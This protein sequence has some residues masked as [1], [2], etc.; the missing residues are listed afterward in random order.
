MERLFEILKTPSEFENSPD[1]IWTNE[2]ISPFIFQSHFNDEVYGGS[3]NEG[4]IV[5]SIKFIN[6]IAEN[7][8]CL[9]ILDLGCGPG[10]YSFPLAKLGYHVTGIDI[11][12]KSIRHANA[13]SYG[14]NLNIQYFKEN[15]LNLQLNSN[16]DMSLLLYEIYSTFNKKQRENLLKI[17]WNGLKDSGIFILDVPS[18]ARYSQQNPIKVWDFYGKGELFIQDPHYLFFSVEKFT[19]DLLLHHSVFWFNDKDI[20]DCY[21]WIQCFNENSLREELSAQGFDILGTYSNL[22]GDNFKKDSLSISI[23]CQKYNVS[24]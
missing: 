7:Y 8:N 18:S 21:D 23:V 11:S 4:F 19:A 3:K 2:R 12:E 17:I 20:V 15:I 1:D 9:E 6:N 14:Q 13:L 24:R 16:Y 22:C 5:N 10:V